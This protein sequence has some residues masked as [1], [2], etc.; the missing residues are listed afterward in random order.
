M[1][2][3][4]IKLYSLAVLVALITT[5]ACGSDDP[6]PVNEEELITT[7]RVTFTGT[8]PNEGETVVA[9]FKDLDGAGGDAPEVVNPVLSANGT[10][11]VSVVFLNEAESPAENITLEVKKEADEHQVFFVASNLNFTYQYGDQDSNAKPL[12]LEG[13]VLIG[14]AGN[15]TLQV[16]LIHEPNKDGSGV[17]GGDPTNAGG[18]TDISVTFNVSVQ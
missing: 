5:T 6:E 12:G 9:T 14:A 4:R 8:G 2:L 15:G 16:L 17:S 11:D 10:Y 13:S 7:L 18:E 1:K 3:T